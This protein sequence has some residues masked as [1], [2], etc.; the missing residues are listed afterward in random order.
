DVRA[1]LRPHLAVEANEMTDAARLR[2]ARRLFEQ[3]LPARTRKAFVAAAK[4]P[5][6]WQSDWT[7]SV[8]VGD[9][10]LPP[11]ADAAIWPALLD[12]YENQ[13]ADPTRMGAAVVCYSCGLRRPFEL[14]P[15]THVGAEGCPYC[16]DGAWTHAHQPDMN[17]P[18]RPQAAE[19]LTAATSPQ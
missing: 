18:W 12:A 15:A 11:D 9:S 10:R 19:E 2:A 5:G 4:V 13:F 1:E 16:G 6:T 8:A 7:A 3:I 14:R 17:A